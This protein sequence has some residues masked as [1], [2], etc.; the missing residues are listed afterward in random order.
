MSDIISFKYSGDKDAYN[1]FK[2]GKMSKGL[3]M[4]ETFSKF[5]DQELI[6][7]CAKEANINQTA[8]KHENDLRDRLLNEDLSRVIVKGLYHVDIDDT[9]LIQ[10][11]T[12]DLAK[13]VNNAVHSAID[14]YWRNRWAII[15]VNNMSED[16]LRERIN[17]IAGKAEQT[18]ETIIKQEKSMCN[19]NNDVF[20]KAVNSVKVTFTCTIPII[21]LSDLREKDLGRVVQFDCII[22]GPTPKKL[23]V[24]TGKYIQNVLIQETESKARNNNPVMIKAIIHGDDTNNIATG[25]TKRFIGIYTTQGPKNGDK[26]ES[27]KTLMID[28]MSIQDLEEQAEVELTQQELTVAKEFA[29]SEEDEYIKKLIV[30]FCPKIYGRELEKKA[31]YLA[32][33]GGSDFEGYRKE[34]HLM[35]VGEADTGKSEMVKFANEVASKSSMIDGSNSTGVGILFALDEYDGMKILR[36]GAMIT[37][38]GGHLMVDEYDKM[39]KQE[40]KKLNIAME[41]QRAKY[42]KGGHM[43]DAEC[44]T[45]V[46]ASC[47][48]EAERWNEGKDLIDNL[49]FDASTISRF[50]LMIR[51][52]HDSSE[53]QVRAKMLHISKNKR[54]DIEQVANPKWVKGLLNHLRKLKP[55][56]TPEAEVL[57]INKF[58]EFTQIEQQD[59]SLQIQTRQMEGIQRLC[60]AWGKLLFRTEIDTK[61][62]EDVINF[63]QECMST[64]GMNVSKGITQMDLRGHSTN[65]EVYFEDCF[66]SLAKDNKEDLVF[67]HDLAEELLKNTKMFYSDDM[68][69]RYIEARK[70]RGWLYEPKVGVL[71]RQ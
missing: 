65:K 53:S 45:T 67:I 58:V 51:L 15:K 59:G 22:I 28:T 34:S 17:N 52:K 39:P 14:S 3:T 20:D 4:E 60:E 2:A 48:P 21:T 23:D 24:E 30:S 68:V 63:Y 31:L 1:K 16:V 42:N 29:H 18:K 10:A 25:Q 69:L 37:N 46:I 35:L 13:R 50:D 8:S 19:I 36:Q 26:V 41:Q 5:I 38:N 9:E 7:D 47:N 40:Q 49:P 57:L 54:G 61:I 6:L 11:T 55:L 33:L 64:L 71:K 32:L 27:E 66:R 12:H 43:G 56:F 70:V 44:K 62:V